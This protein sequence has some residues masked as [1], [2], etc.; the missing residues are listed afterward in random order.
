MARQSERAILARQSSASQQRTPARTQAV[1]T[2]L[3]RWVGTAPV[4]LAEARAQLTADEDHNLYE[5]L[6]L[7]TIQHVE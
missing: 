7:G 3:S 2:A 6:V 4:P 1:K 5:L